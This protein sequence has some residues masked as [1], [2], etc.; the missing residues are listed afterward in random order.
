[1]DVREDWV[2]V[3]SEASYEESLKKADLTP[4]I[5]TIDQPSL[6][7]REIANRSRLGCERRELI[8]DVVRQLIAISATTSS[9]LRYRA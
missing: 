4:S 6:V 5:S 3:D 9:L 2:E 1:M 8:G 7:R